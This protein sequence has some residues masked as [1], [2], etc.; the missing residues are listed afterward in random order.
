VAPLHRVKGSYISGMLTS[1]LINIYAEKSVEAAGAAARTLLEVIT[2]SDEELHIESKFD[3]SLVSDADFASQK[4]IAEILEPLKIPILSEES[5]APEYSNRKDWDYFWLVD[6]LDGTE[7]FLSSRS[8]FAV[9]IALCDKSGPII[10]VVA[11]PLTNTIYFGVEGKGF[12]ICQLDGSNSRRVKTGKA[13]K[14]F[15]LVTSWNEKATVAELSPPGIN[16]LDVV[17][18]PVSGA[19]KFC[20]VALGDAEIHSRTGPYMEWDCAAG[21]GILRSIGIDVYDRNTDERIKYNTK[22]LRVNGL[23]CSRVK[24]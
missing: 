23:Y 1:E 21:D 15:R 14:P 2:A 13:R 22:D 9:N 24:Q 3:G 4:V 7:S 19:L 20:E 12:S 17:A 10:G 5:K 8:G 11:D 18:R 6:P 16:P